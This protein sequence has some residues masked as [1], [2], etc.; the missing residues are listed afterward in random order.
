M[1]GKAK[2]F[3]NLV[4]FGSSSDLVWFLT[5][6]PF[7][8]S[9]LAVQIKIMKEMEPEVVWAA[10]GISCNSLGIFAICGQG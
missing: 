10:L 1:M 7:Q 9:S 3:W 5:T 6:P 8:H 2:P 4:P